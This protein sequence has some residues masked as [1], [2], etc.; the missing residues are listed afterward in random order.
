MN[1]VLEY[2]EITGNII[3]DL[4]SSSDIDYLLNNKDNNK[5]EDIINGLALRAKLTLKQFNFCFNKNNDFINRCLARNIYLT[6]KQI[7]L[8][9]SKNDNGINYNL[10]EN[11]KLKA[12]H[13][14]LLLNRNYRLFP[15]L[16]NNKSVSKKIKQKIINDTIKKEIFK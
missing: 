13:V 5:D 7:D 12:R 6:E 16:L 3:Y 8:L 14:Q 15:Y 4:L 2:Y 10:S 11:I 1:N 9:L